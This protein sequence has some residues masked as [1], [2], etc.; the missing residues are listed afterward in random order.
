MTRFRAKCVFTEFQR[1]FELAASSGKV[2]IL[3]LCTAVKG[4]SAYFQAVLT[5]AELSKKDHSVT[6]QVLKSEM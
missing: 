2:V 4:N 3:L 1:V 5:V 6:S